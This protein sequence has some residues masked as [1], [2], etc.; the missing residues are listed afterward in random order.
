MRRKLPIRRRAARITPAAIEARRRMFELAGAAKACEEARDAAYKR[1]W[2]GNRDYT[3][4]HS[5]LPPCGESCACMAQRAADQE[6]HRELGVRRP[7]GDEWDELMNDLD[8]LAGQ[9]RT[10]PP[11][12]DRIS[13]DD[14]T[15]P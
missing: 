8:R 12:A 9:Q 14:D 1:A 4:Y 5:R 13:T 3:E 6:L 15:R 2:D 7:W 10:E 11:Q